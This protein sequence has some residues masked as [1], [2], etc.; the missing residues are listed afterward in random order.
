MKKL[1]V[2]FALVAA[3]FACANT[4]PKKTSPNTNVMLNC[5]AIIEYAH[6]FGTGIPAQCQK[7]HPRTPEQRQIHQRIVRELRP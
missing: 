2:V 5:R 3:T 7:M 6:A 1:I 4:V